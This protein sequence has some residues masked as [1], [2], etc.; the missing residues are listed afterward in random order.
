[1]EKK[2]IYKTKLE[3]KTDKQL[4]RRSSSINST[5]VEV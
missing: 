5:N 1:M 3:F 4:I 2:N